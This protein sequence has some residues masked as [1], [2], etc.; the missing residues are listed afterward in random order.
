MFAMRSAFAAALTTAI[1]VPAGN[2]I[3]QT[4]A[5]VADI[6]PL[7]TVRLVVPFT[8]GAANDIT[9]RLIG[10]KLAESLGQQFVI[11]NR[12]GSGGVLGAETVAKATPTGRSADRHRLANR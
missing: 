3:A 9:A 10:T 1:V 7:K 6:Y 4:G 2:A 5:N 12:S 11:D 8:P